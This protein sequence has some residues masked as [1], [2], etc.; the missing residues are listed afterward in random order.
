MYR[1]IDYGAMLRDRRRIDAYT[2]ALTSAVSPS[3]VVLDLG[4]GVGTF[5][6]LACRLG[7]ARVYAV[8]PAEVIAVA[9]EHART[10]GFAER[11]QFLQAHGADIDLPEPVDIIIS[12]LGNALPL[13]EEHLPT[14]ISAR[15]RFLKPGGTLIPRRDRLMCAPVSSDELYARIVEPWRSIGGVELHAGETMALQT[16]QA[17]VV[18][19]GELAGEPRCWAELDYETITSPNAH[20]SAEWTIGVPRGSSGSSEGYGS[21]SPEEPRG[22]PRNPEEPEERT[23]HGIALWFESTLHDGVTYTSGPWAEGSVHATLVLPLLRPRSMRA[24]ETLRVQIDSML[25]S[26]RYIWTWT[27]GGERQS[28][29]L[30]QP[31]SAPLPISPDVLSRKVGRDLL[32]LDQSTGVYHV[33][34]ETGAMVWESLQRGE[35][36]DT[37]AHAVAAE[38]DVDLA[39]AAEDV[40]AIV[41]ELQRAKLVV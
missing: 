9:E 4:T 16:P 38:Y 21:S 29:F 1:L 26:G 37:I 12:D 7:A 24:G 14:I 19:R 35:P 36:V 34:N 41:E 5:S 13:F 10:N 30:S 15:D 32:L 40:E 33:L 17:H 6:L 2:R 18:E 22:T 25:V 11:V 3:A 8:E 28:S 31:R 23:I 39:R 27:A 20:G